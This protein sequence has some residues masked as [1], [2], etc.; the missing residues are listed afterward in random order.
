MI[1]YANQ[2]G[3]R[4]DAQVCQ[5]FFFC[6]LVWR[7]ETLTDPLR[8]CYAAQSIGKYCHLEADRTCHST[9]QPLPRIWG[10]GGDTTRRYSVDK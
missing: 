2:A 9:E 5:L 10:L 7:K 1:Y 4:S 3:H 8:H 6:Y